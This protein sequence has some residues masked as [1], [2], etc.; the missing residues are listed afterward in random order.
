[1]GVETPITSRA[2][3]RPKPVSALRLVQIFLDDAQIGGRFLCFG[4]GELRRGNAQPH[5]RVDE[6]LADTAP[7]AVHGA[8]IG[9]RGRVA[10]RGGELVPFHAFAA[11]SRYAFAANGHKSEIG[12]RLGVALLGGE[13]VPVRGL[14][15]IFGDPSPAKYMLPRLS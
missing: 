5:I 6:V 13:A 1:M 10:L 3:V 2:R 11:V 8:K 4:A 7:H 9:L 12:L 14:M 15:Q